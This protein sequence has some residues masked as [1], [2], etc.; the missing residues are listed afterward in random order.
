MMFHFQYQIKTEISDDFAVL[1]TSH[2][3][4]HQIRT[5]VYLT[6]LIN[7]YC[8]NSGIENLTGATAGPSR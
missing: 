8:K 3:V 2:R 4:L 5:N 6:T 7:S 1:C